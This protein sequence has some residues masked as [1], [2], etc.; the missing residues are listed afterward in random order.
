MASYLGTQG[1]IWDAQQD[2]FLAFCGAILSTTIVSTV[3]KIFK[4]YEPEQTPLPL[5]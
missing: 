4:V 1:D 5:Q 2:I 3:K